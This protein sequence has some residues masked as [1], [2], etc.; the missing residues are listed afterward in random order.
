MSIIVPIKKPLLTVTVDHMTADVVRSADTEPGRF[1]V[2][3]NRFYVDA[4]GS[5]HLERCWFLAQELPQLRA[6]AGLTESKLR[7]LLLSGVIGS[8]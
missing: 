7:D 5:E 6:I 1:T 2:N 4:D 8:P 3:L